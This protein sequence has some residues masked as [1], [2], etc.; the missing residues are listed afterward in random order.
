GLP[1]WW[2]VCANSGASPRFDHRARGPARLDRRPHRRLRVSVCGRTHR[3]RRSQQQISFP[4]ATLCLPP[5]VLLP[6]ETGALTAAA[7][8]SAF[9]DQL[10]Q[11]HKAFDVSE[12]H[13]TADA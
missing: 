8:E 5:H 1:P 12:S 3:P 11:V 6:A 10:L 4:S 2:T 7:V 9:S 13:V